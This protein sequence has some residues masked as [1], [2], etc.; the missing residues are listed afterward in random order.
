MD[1]SSHV[2]KHL[3]QGLF[4]LP[5]ASR[6]ERVT[7]SPPR[8]DPRLAHR[9]TAFRGDERDATGFFAKRSS[10][11][12]I[13]AVAGSEQPTST[14]RRGDGNDR[15]RPLRRRRRARRTRPS[16]RSRRFRRPASLPQ[17][18][19]HLRRRRDTPRM[20]ETMTAAQGGRRRS[21]RNAEA[22]WSSFS[23]SSS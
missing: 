10:P 5:H 6:R 12:R 8:T 9:M 4:R 22:Q 17:T 7:P 21:T 20:P 16:S 1:F 2:E 13:A 11:E 15:T 18:A 23:I 3:K 14:P 19:V